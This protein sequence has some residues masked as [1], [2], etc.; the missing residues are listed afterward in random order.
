MKFIRGEFKY[1]ELFDLDAEAIEIRFDDSDFS[2]VLILPDVLRGLFEL[3]ATLKNY[4]FTK[5]IDRMRPQRIVT[6]IPIFQI[7]HQFSLKNMAN[8][9]SMMQITF[10]SDSSLMHR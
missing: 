10:V 4:D 9:V 6:K 3:E 2:L 7:K 5:I 1:A 8:P